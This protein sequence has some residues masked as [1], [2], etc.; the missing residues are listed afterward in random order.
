MVPPWGFVAGSRL[1][2]RI[3]RGESSVLRPF[4]AWRSCQ[5]PLGDRE[6]RSRSSPTRYAEARALMEALELAEPVA[7]TL[8]RRG[9]RTVE[10]ARALPGG[11]RGP[12]P[13]RVRLDGGGRR[14]RIGGRSPPGARITVHGDYDCD[15]V[16]ST[17]ILVRRAARARAPTATGTSPTA[18]ATATGSPRRAVERLAAR[19]TG[20]LITADC[21]I[22][23]A[24]EVA[25]ARAAGMEVIVTDH[26]QPGRA[27]SRLPDPAPALSRLPVR[28]ALRH[29]RRLQARGGA[30]R[31]RSG[32]AAATST[33]W[34]WR[35]SPT[36]SRCGART[37]P[38]SA[39]ARGARAAARGR[40][41]GRCARPRRSRPSASTRATSP[42]A[43]AP[44]I[45]AAGRLYRADAGVELMLTDDDERAARDRG[46]AR[47]RQPRAPRHR[48]GGARARP[49]ARARELPAELAVGAGAGARRRRAGIPGVVGIVASRLAERHWRPVVLIG[50]DAEG[51]GPRLGTQHPGL[52]PARRRWTPAAST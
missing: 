44:R 30:A 6:Q 10:E 32:A 31:R 7:V 21:G 39:R 12:R 24:D 40:G 11:R 28:R 2:S 47:P 13:V 33:W 36:W 23:C 9:Y 14:E 41:C 18:S 16:C 15:G 50:L 35:P 1:C 3:K 49:S 19:G 25:A 27:A 34:R 42:S 37:G 43:S 29:R 48:A 17:A 8:V 22:T 5:R 26:H 38:S 4:L 45:N 52:R 20:L 46:R 51:R